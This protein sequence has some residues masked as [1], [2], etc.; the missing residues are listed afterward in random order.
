MFDKV[1]ARITILATL[2]S[3]S[4]A[5]LLHSGCRASNYQLD[6]FNKFCYSDLAVYV[7]EGVVAFS[8][9][10]PAVAPLSHILLWIV[11]GISAF[12]IKIVVLQIIIALALVVTA[13]T[14]Q[15]FRGGNTYDGLLFVVLPFTPLTLFIGF[16]LLAIAIATIAIYLYKQNRDS[17]LPWVL[18]AVAIGFDGWTWI[19]AAAAVLY[20]VVSKRLVSLLKLFPIFVLTLGV[21]NLPIALTTRNFFN[22]TPT[23][24]DGTAMYVL[25]LLG[26]FTPPTHFVPYYFA[27][28]VL[29]AISVWLYYEYKK[30]HFRYEVVLLLFVCV[31]TYNTNAITP[32]DL[33]HVLW[34]LLL[35]YP[36][37]KFVVTISSLFVVWVAAVWLHAEELLGER[38]IDTQWYV[39]SVAVAWVSIFMCGLKAAEIVHTPGKDPVLNGTV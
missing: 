33:V 10:S 38:G 36:V 25:S 30:H 22:I 18:F 14:L 3:S 37:R 27:V 23:L 19:V 9:N 6:V 39:I 32:G 7:Q 1:I 11:G 34:A 24:G 26:N 35:A 28:L 13:L 16:N 15:I 29:L 17:Y 20:E 4:F 5:F 2:V 12:E 8:P 21:I 31:Q